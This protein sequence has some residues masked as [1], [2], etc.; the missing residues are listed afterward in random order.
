M[1]QFIEFL[2]FSFDYDAGAKDTKSHKCFTLECY[3]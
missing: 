3:T 1:A 2:I